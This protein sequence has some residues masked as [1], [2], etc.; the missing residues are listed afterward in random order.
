METPWSGFSP[1]DQAKIK[2]ELDDAERLKNDLQDADITENKEVKSPSLSKKSKVNSKKTPHFLN[3]NAHHTDG[4]PAE[5]LFLTKTKQE[6]GSESPVHVKLRI[7]ED[8]PTSFEIMETVPQENET[9]F[10]GEQ[11][12]LETQDVNHQVDESPCS[13]SP[14]SALPVDLLQNGGKK[15]LVNLDEF[16]K[17]QKLIE[18]QNRLKKQMLAKALALRKMKTQTEALKLQQI[19]EELSKLDAN[20]SN[21]VCILRSHIEMASVELA[22]AEKR[23]MKAEHEF[24]E[25]KQLLFS[26]RE[27]KDLLTEH[28]CTI[29]EQNEMRKA[30]RLT[31]LMIQLD[32]E[33]YRAEPSVQQLIDPVKTS[34]N[35]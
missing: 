12:N 9:V 4:L 34:D 30:R 15:N 11:A 28:L 8:R 5:A 18:E 33:E 13:Q 3:M 25:A 19:Q 16:E 2:S 31:D 6:K 1:A 29:I 21:D 27:R 7:L 35:V 20:L 26:K 32:D 23:Y 10:T 14:N 17:K 24:V 22:E